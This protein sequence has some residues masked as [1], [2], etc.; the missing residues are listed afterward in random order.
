MNMM[1]QQKGNSQEEPS[2]PQQKSLDYVQQSQ[3]VERQGINNFPSP[4]FELQM[5]AQPSQNWLA[6]SEA[7]YRRE[8]KQRFPK[9]SA[10]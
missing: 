4:F 7:T 3:P 8:I 10:A 5:R 1:T 9:Y 6:F 2:A